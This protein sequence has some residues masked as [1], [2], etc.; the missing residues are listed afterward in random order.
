MWKCC[1]TY[2]SSLNFSDYIKVSHG[3]EKEGGRYKKVILADIFE[4]FMGAVYL[5]LGFDTVKKVILDIIVPYVLDK[6]ITFFSDYKSSLQECVQ[7]EQKSLEYN[8]V[9]EEGPL[10]IRDLQ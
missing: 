4:A 8:L 7:T 9:N 6:N 5:D 3:E 1:S 10:M 2:A